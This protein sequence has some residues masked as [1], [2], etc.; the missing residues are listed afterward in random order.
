MKLTK[1]IRLTPTDSYASFLELQSRLVNQR[2]GFTNHLIIAEHPPVITLGRREHPNYDKVVNSSQCRVYK[3]GRGGQATYHGPGQLCAYPIIDL[4][5]IVDERMSNGLLHW[6][7]DQLLNLLL[8]TINNSMSFCSNTGVHVKSIGKVG[9]VGFQVSRW[10]T[11]FGIS[12]NVRRE[13]LEGFKGIVPCGKPE[14]QIGC[15]E[16]IE[17][18]EMD[19]VERRF[20]DAYCKV[21]ETSIT[22]MKNT[23]QKQQH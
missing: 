21:F 11:S 1:L 8:T 6:Y 2:D 14:M 10:V 19:R 12:V 23:G 18:I 13:C 4:N 17:E 20:V 9:F 5:G 3:V 7:S 15:L 16:Q 22:R